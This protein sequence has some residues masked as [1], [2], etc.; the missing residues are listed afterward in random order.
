[1]K[2]NDK[3]LMMLERMF[4][5]NNTLRIADIATQL[6]VGRT[7]VY[8]Y[9]RRLEEKGYVF[10]EGRSGHAV[11]FTIENMASELVEYEPLT[12][13]SYNKYMILKTLKEIGGCDFLRLYRHICSQENNCNINLKEIRL[14]QLVKELIESGDIEVITSP[15][16]KKLLHSAGSNIPISVM[17]ET[18]EDMWD[19]YMSLNSI[20]PGD[21]H[22]NQLEN[23]RNRLSLASGE[24][25]ED[26]PY[27][28]NYIVY[29]SSNPTYTRFN[30]LMAN[31]RM[32]PYKTKAI[33][34]SYKTRQGKLVTSLIKT[35]ALIYSHEKDVLYLM[36]SNEKGDDTIINIAQ[37]E[38]L[39]SSDFINADYNSAHFRKIIDEMFSISSEEPVDVEIWFDNV[40]R[41][42]DKVKE[43]AK[44]RKR[45]TVVVEEKYIVY[46]DTVR[47]LNDLRNYLRQFG[48]ACHVIKP[49]E[50]EDEMRASVEKSLSGYCD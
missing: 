20:S 6:G 26:S 9:V 29:G 38:S 37:I 33:Y 1:M 41:I 4:L 39:I 19:L 27:K 32:V 11:T 5:E 22:Y 21:P 34:V 30:E 40:Y 35:G 36:G 7:S 48:R 45:A 12:A 44:H 14:R 16:N 17:F 8:N 18:N 25:L 3:R 50:L 47:G 2:N 15:D 24:V 31:M 10:K 28:D 42:S 49:K 23:L 43:M 46:K 13:E